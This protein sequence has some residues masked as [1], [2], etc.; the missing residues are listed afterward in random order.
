MTDNNDGT[1][2]D[3]QEKKL[4]HYSELTPGSLIRLK[5][6]RSLATWL[7]VHDETLLVVL[8]W[9]CA[10]N[11]NS[12]KTFMTDRA[13]GSIGSKEA[14]SSGSMHFAPVMVDGALATLVVWTEDDGWEP[15]CSSDAVP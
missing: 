4:H 12:R 11:W 6:R 2:A 8:P 13:G 15:V 10:R 14:A 3:G 5:A 1:S 9:E 7:P